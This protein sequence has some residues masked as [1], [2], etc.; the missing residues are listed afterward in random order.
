MLYKNYPDRFELLIRVSVLYAAAVMGIAL[1]R[2]FMKRLPWIEAAAQAALWIYLYVLFG[3]TVFTRTKKPNMRF[4][5]EFLWSWRELIETR[6]AYSFMQIF[7]NILMLSPFGLL[8]PASERWFRRFRRTLLAGFLVSCS[9]ETMQ[10]L[11]QR[12]MFELDDI[13]HNTLGAAAGYGLYFLAHCL[14]KAVHP[15]KRC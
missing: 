12:G 2:G 4:E 8:L 13:L 10:L 14:R 11:L 7:G 5:L 15:E 1:V 6:D 3:F 9:V